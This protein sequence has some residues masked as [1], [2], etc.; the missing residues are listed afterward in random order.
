MVK[1]I[2]LCSGIEA[3]T[4]A[5]HSFGWTPTAFSEIEPFAC[6]VLKHHYPDVPNLGNM[7]NWREWDE[8]ILAESSVIIAGTPCQGFSVAGLRKGLSD[9]R[10]KLT[11]EFIKIIDRIDEIRIARGR[12]PVVV[13]WENVPGVLSSKDNAF[14]CFLGGLVGEDVQLES[15]GKRWTDA[16]YVR[17]PKRAVAWRILDAQY[18]G[19]AQRRRRVF[20]VAGAG[21]GFHPEKVLFEFEGL[22]R[23]TPPSRK[24]G[25]DIAPTIASRSTAGGGLGT[26]FDCDGGLVVESGMHCADVAPT[27]GASGPPFSRVGNERVETEALVSLMTVRESGKGYW[28]EDDVA[29]TLE[30]DHIAQR[31][32]IMQGD[33]PESDDRPIAFSSKDH[34]AD[35]AVDLSPTLRAMPHDTSHANGGGQMAI[36]IRTAQT[37]S[38][39]HGFSDELSYTLDRAQGQAVAFEP[40]IAKRE[41]N[42]NRFVEECSPTLRNDMGDNQVAVC[43]QSKASSNQ[44]MNPSEIAPTMDVAKAD[45]LATIVPNDISRYMVRRLICEE[46]EKL[47]GFPVGYTKIPWK[48]KSA[49]KCPDGN[50]YRALGNSMAVPVIAW[51]G[52]RIEANM[53][54]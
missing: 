23:D 25:K 50:R 5:W 52:K 14:G 39:G 32:V 9:D 10:G 3:A 28:M 54:E 48:N 6:A 8:E 27:M 29:G 21:E 18:F 44:S 17:G 42:P 7:L 24:T 47:Q 43:F 4:V 30:R 53:E 34:G 31:Q 16:G 35:A 11:I 51:I 33:V 1:Y 49:D 46:T 26:D 40:G 38:N 19:L 13:L 45:G 2:S 20:A 12:N 37:S 22:R 36:A 15:P 41:C